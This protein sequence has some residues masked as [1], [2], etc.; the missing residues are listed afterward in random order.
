MG[1]LQEYEPMNRS[2]LVAALAARFKD[3]SHDDAEAAVRT[4]FS[5]LANAMI[6][7]KRIEIRGF[8]SFELRYRCQRTARNPKTGESVTVPERYT[9]HFRAGKELRER[10]IESAAANGGSRTSTDLL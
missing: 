9:P 2:D 3:L 8:G 7:G 5:A 4:I 10:V 1:R 6:E